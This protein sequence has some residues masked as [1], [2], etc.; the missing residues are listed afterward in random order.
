[1]IFVEKSPKL[2]KY[3]KYQKYREISTHGS[4]R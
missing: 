1:M 2:E 3:K 4:S